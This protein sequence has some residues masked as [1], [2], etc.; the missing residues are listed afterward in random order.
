LSAKYLSADICAKKAKIE[1]DIANIEY[2]DE[3]FDVIDYSHV[4]EHILAD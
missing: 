2:P 1:M 4:L 3:T